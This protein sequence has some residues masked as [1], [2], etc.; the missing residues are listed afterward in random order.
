MRLIV[1]RHGRTEWNERGLIQGQ[2]ET[3]L[4]EAGRRQVRAWTLPQGWRELPCVTSPLCRAIETAELLGLTIA[5]TEPRLR[6]M[7]WGRF[8]G[9]TLED[10]RAEHG[11]WMVE[12]E[13]MGLDFRPPGGESPRDVTARVRSYLDEAAADGRDRIIVAHKGVRRAL[14]V[15]AFDWDMLGKPP[16]RLADDEALIL[17]LNHDGHIVEARPYSL[18]TAP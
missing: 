4:S 12:A 15:L 18:V 2:C 5:A 6:E 1:L 7:D 8:G 17:K 9:R 3:A 14:L 11:G 10:L 13:A 16:L